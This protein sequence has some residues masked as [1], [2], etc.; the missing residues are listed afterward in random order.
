MKL[1]VSHHDEGVVLLYDPVG[2]DLRT[3]KYALQPSSAPQVSQTHG[4]T[5]KSKPTDNSL[6]GTVLDQTP[7]RT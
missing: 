5:S 6:S 1:L 4:D 3:P 2:K 7:V